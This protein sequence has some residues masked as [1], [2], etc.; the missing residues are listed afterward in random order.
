MHLH[1]WRKVL[2]P[3]GTGILAQNV[4]IEITISNLNV[5]FCSCLQILSPERCA[6]RFHL[7]L[8][9]IRGP[10]SFLIVWRLGDGSLA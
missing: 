5:V 9:E 6:G 1:Y 3:S 8:E 10:F 4:C 7:G 2:L